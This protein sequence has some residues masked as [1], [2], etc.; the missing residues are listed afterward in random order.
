[1]LKLTDSSYFHL[2]AIT[3][4]ETI[5]LTVG[6]FCVWRGNSLLT[7]IMKVL[8]IISICSPVFWPLCIDFG[9]VLCYVI[10]LW[11]IMW[12]SI[13]FLLCLYISARNETKLSCPEYDISVY[14]YWGKHHACIC[15]PMYLAL[16]WKA[17]I[18]RPLWIEVTLAHLTVLY[19]NMI[20]MLILSR[21]Y[22]DMKTGILEKPQSDY[23]DRWL[24]EI[25]HYE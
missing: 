6:L 12:H 17:N 18:T 15:A 16:I 4:V 10:T 8:Q 19:Q 20:L 1:M 9:K 21:D 7:K 11:S 25:V 5:L 24:S 23:L 14:V 2:Y 13:V 3:G 22:E